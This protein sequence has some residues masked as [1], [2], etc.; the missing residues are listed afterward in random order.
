MCKSQCSHIKLTTEEESAAW[1]TTVKHVET[2]Q[3]TAS[4]VCLLVCQY[5]E[6]KKLSKKYSLLQQMTGRWS[7]KTFWMS[8]RNRSLAGC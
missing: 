2:S 4:L 8:L 3:L 6:E 5:E 7:R 1:A